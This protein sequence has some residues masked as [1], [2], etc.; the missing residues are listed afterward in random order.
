MKNQAVQKFLDMV[1]ADKSLESELQG[2]MLS[3]A[4]P[5]AALE[6]AVDLAQVRGLR[7]TA[8]DLRS[9]LAQIPVPPSS[10][11][12]ALN[13]AELG[14]VAGGMVMDWARA[15]IGSETIYCYICAMGTTG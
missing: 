14:A 15:T 12:G 9:Q 11:S 5:K 8:E 4:S 1:K 7:I 10:M 2:A 6:K 3:A 13:D